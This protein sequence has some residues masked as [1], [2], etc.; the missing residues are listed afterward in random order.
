MARGEEARLTQV[1][2]QGAWA[3]TAEQ[4]EAWAVEANPG[5]RTVYAR[6]AILPRGAGIDA[7]RS[8][9]EE[10]EV[11]LN[12]RRVGPDLFDYLATRRAVP[13]SPMGGRGTGANLV[14]GPGKRLLDVLTKLAT[15][16]Q[17]CPGNL[18]LAKLTGFETPQ[19]VAY[20][21]RKLIQARAVRVVTDVL[22]YRIVT[23]S[24]TGKR[25]APHPAEAQ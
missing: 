8:L 22:G 23:I 20:H 11:I 12:L 16:E 17:P 21:L 1:A 13:R 6:G 19:K 9:H 10:G 7:M 14:D 3:M 15:R 24:R 4:V 5:E 25:T 18:Q 2:Q